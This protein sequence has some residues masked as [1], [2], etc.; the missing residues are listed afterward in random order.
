MIMGP[1]MSWPLCGI[2]LNAAEARR[3]VAALPDLVRPTLAG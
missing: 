2:E 3:S 1:C